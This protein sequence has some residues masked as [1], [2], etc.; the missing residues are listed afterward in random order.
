MKVI[1]SFNE[2]ENTKVVWKMF[3]YSSSLL[4]LFIL[5]KY[6]SWQ[7]V[8]IGLKVYKNVAIVWHH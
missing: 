7:L 8:D 2:N 3:D 6:E 1:F 5:T 4:D